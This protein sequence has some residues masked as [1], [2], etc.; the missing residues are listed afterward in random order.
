MEKG[1][2]ARADAA[3]A[4]VSWGRLSSLRTTT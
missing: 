1:D 4:I 3:W 2:A